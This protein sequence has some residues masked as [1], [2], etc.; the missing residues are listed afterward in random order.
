MRVDIQLIPVP[1]NPDKLPNRTVV[2][3]DILRAG[4]VIVHALSQG[5]T[6]VIPVTTVEEAFER[7][8]TFPPGT[9]LLGGERGS[10]KIEG[11]DLG[12][13]PEEYTAERVRGKRVILTTTNGT[14][15]FHLVSAA[16]EIFVGSFFN[17]TET[18]NRCLQ[19]GRNILLFASGS[20][21]HFSLEDSVFGGML[22]DRMLKRAGKSIHLSDASR[23]A[24][25]LYQRFEGNLVEAFLLSNHGRDLVELGLGDDLATCS[26]IDQTTLVP[27]FKDGVIR[28]S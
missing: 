14:K 20:R 15:A 3:I 26:K 25:V 18:A 9:T 1:P 13:S 21:G 10:R 24:H 28:A 4:S 7:G 11:F 23:A 2:V 17:V 27:I 8:K 12:N 16:T 19:R 5:A 22:V 6:E